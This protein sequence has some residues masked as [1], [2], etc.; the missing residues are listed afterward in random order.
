ME[1][2]DD[3]QA[4]EAISMQNKFLSEHLL[5]WAPACLEQ[6]TARAETSLYKI[7]SRLLITFLLQEQSVTTARPSLTVGGNQKTRSVP[8]F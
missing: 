5:R 8:V 3:E 4:D 1:A 2:H 6:I 7:L